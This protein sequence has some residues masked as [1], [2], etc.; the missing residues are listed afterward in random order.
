MSRPTVVLAMVPLLT[1]EV[2]DEDSRARLRSL[3]EVLDFEPL[4]AFEDARA[5]ELLPRAEVLLTG[6][7]CP[8][9]GAG[10]LAKAPR[11]RAI[12]HAAGT[13]KDHVTDACWE[14]GLQVTSAAA[15][16]ALP[17]AE[18]TLAAILFAN[19]RAF[20]I[21]RRYAELREFRWWPL[22][23]PGLGNYA[24]VVGIV[25]ASF[26]GRR[27]IELLKPFD[28]EIVVFDPFLTEKDAA[29]LGVR[30][31]E[32][33]E[34]MHISDIVS[35]HAP[36]LP[37][38]RALISREMLKSMKAGATFINTA[39]GSI[40][41]GD[42]LAEE[43]ASRRIYAVIDTTEPEILPPESPLYDLPNV[44]LT[45]HIA[46]A[47]GSETRRLGALAVDEIGR[48]AR[49]EPFRYAIRREDLHRLA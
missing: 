4:T 30:K 13:V 38:T 27:V 47:M 29:V 5:L 10:T 8:P 46:G 17:V 21:Q 16:N 37:D 32:L 11:L 20:P 26:V 48:Y 35:L 7:G 28:F 45:P 25:G 43:L 6:W 31:V 12:I 1:A 19:K 49:G 18:Y 14:R 42:A 44:F 9:I 22:E 23:F 39:R 34:L 3:T 15:A 36:A 41:D 33:E 24:K 2:F 40:V